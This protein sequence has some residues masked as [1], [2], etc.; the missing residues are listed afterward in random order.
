ME[1]DSWLI[2]LILEIWLTASYASRTSGWLF[3]CMSCQETQVLADFHRVVWN[4]LNTAFS[5]W[6]QPRWR[7]VLGSVQRTAGT[8]SMGNSS[9]VTEH[10]HTHTH[11]LSDPLQAELIKKSRRSMSCLNNDQ[12]ETETMCLTSHSTMSQAHSSQF[13]VAW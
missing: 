3:P 8:V 2:I 6:Q 13:T 4:I 11:Q 5:P 12:K 7:S 10:T 1:Q 9:A